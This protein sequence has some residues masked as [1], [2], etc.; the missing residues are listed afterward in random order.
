MMW[1]DMMALV[2]ILVAALGV[3]LI[4]CMAPAAEVVEQGHNV[5]PTGRW[6][7][8]WPGS[9][10]QRPAPAARVVV[11]KPQ[12]LVYFSY[13]AAPDA[14]GGGG[15]AGASVVVCAICLEALVAGAECS[16]VPACRHVFHRGCLALWIKSKS[17]CPLC[18]EL[19]VAGSEPIT[20][21][22]AMV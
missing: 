21:A 15:T 10:R 22:E 18:R 16:E 4:W 8:R 17:T 20:A 19:V 5:P 9:Q 2:A 7:G 14:E 1:Q 13:P 11:G 6:R 12:Q 3:C